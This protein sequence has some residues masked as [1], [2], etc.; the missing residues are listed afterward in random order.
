[1]NYSLVL[2]EAN[3][4]SVLSAELL[5]RLIAV[6]ERMTEDAEA[7]KAFA[8]RKLDQAIQHTFEGFPVADR[9]SAN[10]ALLAYK[11]HFSAVY[12][13]GQNAGRSYFHRI[14]GKLGIPTKSALE[15]EQRKQPPRTVHVPVAAAGMLVRFEEAST[16]TA[17]EIHDP[18][19]LSIVA[20]WSPANPTAV[21]PDSGEV[22]CTGKT[23]LHGE[24]PVLAASGDG[25]RAMS[26]R[27]IEGS[28][29]LGEF[30]E[31]DSEHSEDGEIGDDVHAG[32]EGGGEDPISEPY[33]GGSATCTKA[34]GITESRGELC[35]QSIG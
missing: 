34:P 28:L 11:Q 19:I 16:S 6:S 17:D 31:T 10:P 15:K 30:S 23:V 21:L 22:P 4:E 27:K 3:T 12:P 33:V 18:A 1:M 32:E 26:K 2:Q 25:A 7:L 35:F 8:L 9:H 13:A 14:C 24:V 5:S 29:A 20:R